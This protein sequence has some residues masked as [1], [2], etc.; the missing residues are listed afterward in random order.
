MRTGG[1]TSMLQH[2]IEGTKIIVTGTLADAATLAK[3]KELPSFGNNKANKKTAKIT[4]HNAEKWN[5]Y[6]ANDDNY[7][8]DGSYQDLIKRVTGNVDMKP[9]ERALYSDTIAKS[10]SRTMSAAFK[11]MPKRKRVMSEYDGDY[12]HDRRFD[13]AP[14]ILAK[15]EAVPARTITLRCFFAAPG[16]VNGDE[17]TRFGTVIWAICQTIE[18]SGIPVKVTW[19]KRNERMSDSTKVNKSEI[20]LTLKDFGQYLSPS[21]LA[22]VF[23]GVFY[24]R[25]GLA[26]ICAAAELAKVAVCGSLGTPVAPSG[27]TYEHGVVNLSMGALDAGRVDELIETIKRAVA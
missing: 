24:R 16:S 8:C 27:F 9:Y 17:I 4:E 7:W 26:L 21:I 1:V 23:S 14:F 15:R 11:P 18:K 25:I 3:S 20:E 6:I 12:Q 19:V 10:V 2:R 22:A 13:I 5:H